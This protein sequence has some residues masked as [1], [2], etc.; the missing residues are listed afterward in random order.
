MLLFSPKAEAALQ[1]LLIEK[2]IRHR[3]S[4]QHSFPLYTHRRCGVG[5]CGETKKQ[6]RKYA[7]KQNMF[8]ENKRICLKTGYTAKRGG[9]SSEK[10]MQKKWHI[11]CV[12]QPLRRHLPNSKTISPVQHGYAALRYIRTGSVPQQMISA[13]YGRLCRSE[14]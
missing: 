4:G 3:F 13:T 12:K 2:I 7:D 6:G 9:L 10:K 8:F 11:C 14:S 1:L 5:H